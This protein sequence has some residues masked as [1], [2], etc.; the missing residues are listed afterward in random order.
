MGILQAIILEWVTMLSSRGSSQPRD[1]TQVSSLQVDSLPSEPLGKPKN[2]R[3]GSLSLLQGIFLTQGSNQGHIADGFFTSW[4]S[5]EAPLM[6]YR[7]S[8][9]YQKPRPFLIFL[10][11]SFG[12]FPFSSWSQGGCHRHTHKMPWLKGM[13]F[14]LLTAKQISS[15]HKTGDSVKKKEEVWLLGRKLTVYN[16]ILMI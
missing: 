7:S 6:W 12:L 16:T 13:R 14:S 9:C 10:S 8:K 3:V 5:R 2:T 11:A 1:G 4:A 15:L